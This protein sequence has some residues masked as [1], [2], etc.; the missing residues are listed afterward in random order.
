[1][2]QIQHPN[3]SA[4]F[5]VNASTANGF[6][7]PS[8]CDDKDKENIAPPNHSNM[9]KNLNKLDS[10]PKKTVTTMNVD[11][12]DACKDPVKLAEHYKNLCK[13]FAE[14]LETRGGEL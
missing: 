4:L 2:K 8:Y 14:L 12:I 10:F 13:C 1:M 9:Q 11:E 7:K 5:N 6:A 3:S